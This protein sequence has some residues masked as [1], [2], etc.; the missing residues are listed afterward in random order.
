MKRFFKILLLSLPLFIQL[1]AGGAENLGLAGRVYPIVEKDALSEFEDRAREVNF[2]QLFKPE[3]FDKKITGFKPKGLKMLPP[4]R[5]NNSRLVDVSISLQDHIRDQNG[6]ILYPKG[7][8]VNPFDYASL[9]F[10][11]IV[12]NG[13]DSDEIAWFEKSPLFKNPSNPILISDGSYSDLAQ[14]W[15]RPIY[16][17]TA[18]IIGRFEVHGTPSIISQNGKYLNVDEVFIYNR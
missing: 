4:V 12:L 6:N 11:I 8:R 9:P 15:Q 5:K 7:L 13:A 2:F 16:Y 17:A 3:D 10:Q 14:K 18:E 1:R